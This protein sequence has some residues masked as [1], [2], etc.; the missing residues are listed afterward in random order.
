M[1]ESELK[2][3][4]ITS[5]FLYKEKH[6]NIDFN[7]AMKNI[8]RSYEKPSPYPPYE[9]NKHLFRTIRKDGK[10][11]AHIAMLEIRPKMWMGHH[12]M[13]LNK[14]YGKEVFMQFAFWVQQNYGTKID[15]LI[16]YYSPHK[17][18]I[19]LYEK[20]KEY[21]NDE[22]EC[23]TEKVSIIKKHQPRD[24]KYG[25][26]LSHLHNSMYHKPPRKNEKKYIRWTF[27]CTKENID[28]AFEYFLK[29]K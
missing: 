9:N 26:N 27:K 8:M 17:K 29:E 1:T 21:V 25:L 14:G 15:T 28:K 20:I 11:V 22:K 3:L 19:T 4:M 7:L 6:D 16:A 10:L 12:H 24:H 18:N 23:Y 5:K 13:S 2:N